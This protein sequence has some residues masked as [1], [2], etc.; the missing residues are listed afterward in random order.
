MSP[1]WGRLK[2]PLGEPVRLK[3]SLSKETLREYSTTLL[4]NN[5]QDDICQNEYSSNIQMPLKQPLKTQERNIY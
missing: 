3:I 5:M 1:Y 4:L 2:S